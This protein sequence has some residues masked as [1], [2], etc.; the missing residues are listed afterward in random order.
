MTNMPERIKEM[1]LR[2]LAKPTIL[3]VE[4][5][6]P[7][8]ELLVEILE[9]E[10]FEVLSAADG[11]SALELARRDE[12]R[13]D[14]LLTE[15]IPRG[16]RVQELTRELYRRHAHM[17]ILF[18]AGKFDEGVAS[19]LGDQA[20]RLFLLKPFTRQTLLQKINEILG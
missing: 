10:G 12:Q 17:R 18:M 4:S 1:R 14:L 16:M 6:F 15:A 13:I 20:E 11:P 19:A 8:R 2:F 3:V 7:I 5:A 9:A